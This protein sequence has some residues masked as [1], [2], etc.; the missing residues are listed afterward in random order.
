MKIIGIIIGIGV[1]VII[2]GLLLT[3]GSGSIQNRGAEEALSFSST[4]EWGEEYLVH[5]ERQYYFPSLAGW[6]DRVTLADFPANDSPE[7][8]EELDLLLQYQEERT[9]AQIN[10]T[11]SE[12][13]ANN[14]IFGGRP[15]G[16]Y[17][18]ENFPKTT[19]LIT[20]GLF[21]LA[22]PI[23]AT[24]LE[25]DRVRPHFLDARLKPAIDVPEHAAYPSGHSTQAHFVAGILSLL[26]PELE[27]QYFQEA[28]Q[29]AKN[30]EIVG[31]HYPTDSAVGKDLALQVIAI[32]LEDEKFQKLILEARKEW[33]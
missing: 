12:I 23:I 17:G 3:Q 9:R 20:E 21:D 13:D 4:M 26:N 1:L 29:I 28:A 32:L 24:K 30:R 15:I 7:T 22:R 16:S 8:R 27:T 2:G 19:I 25:F 18:Q 31:V 10:Q 11:I 6:E 33:E 5:L 14:F